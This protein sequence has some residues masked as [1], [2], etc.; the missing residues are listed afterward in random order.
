MH[1]KL[2]KFEGPLELLWEL[3]EA[4]RLAVTE[5]ALAE[6]TDQ[7]LEIVSQQENSLENLA[8]F[9]L[10]ASRLL[11]IKSKSLLPFLNLSPEEEREIKELQ[12][13]LEEYRRYKQQSKIVKEI[14]QRRQPSATRSLWQGREV[15]F[16]PA[17]NV[18]LEALRQNFAKVLRLCEKFAVPQKEEWLQRTI[19]L[20]QK[21]K[22]ISD[23]IQ[24]Q[25][26]T[27]LRNLTGS[28]TKKIDA[29][30]CF[31]A[32]LFLFRQKIV[33]LEQGGYA[34]DILVKKIEANG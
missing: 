20:E 2:G 11:L 27:S 31:L 17:Q 6:V 3:I 34:S 24:T 18:S 22:K 16:Y 5:I 33:S 30:L 1:F 29:I 28:G 7:Y 23:K 8:D 21:I 32:L 12:F 26:Q 9:L 10:I 4:K 19:S 15:F 14:L 25:A 13:S